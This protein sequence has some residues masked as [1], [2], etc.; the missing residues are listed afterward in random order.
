[1]PVA[2]LEYALNLKPDVIFVLSEKITGS[3]KFEIDRRDL[4]AKLNQLNPVIDDKTGRRRTQINCI[5]FREKDVLDTLRLIAEVHGGAN[6]YKF[7]SDKELGL[8]AP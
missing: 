3:G 6:G 1:N 5:Q 7:V 4:L 2:A 8:E